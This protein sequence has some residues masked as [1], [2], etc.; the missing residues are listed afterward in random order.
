MDRE[1]D[2]R[3]LLAMETLTDKPRFA[4]LRMVPRVGSVEIQS[5]G[6][7]RLATE[8]RGALRP[9]QHLQIIGPQKKD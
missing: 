8:A 7:E 5:L 4:P 6:R 3:V 2:L 9:W 1:A